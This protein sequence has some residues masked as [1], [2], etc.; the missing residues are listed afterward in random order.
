MNSK[1]HLVITGGSGMLGSVIATEFR[2]AGWTVDAPGSRELDVRDH[3]AV[4]RY[5]SDRQPEL[6][7]CAAGVIRDAPIARLSEGD[8]D[9]VWSVNF[10][11]ALTCAGVV[12][13]GMMDRGG[14]HVVFISSFSALSP[15]S[16]QTAYAASKAALIGLAR[17]LARDHGGSNIRVNTVLPGFLE[18]RMTSNVT[19][20]R[21]REVL[22][23]HS[24]S[25]LNTCDRVAAF[26]RFL[27]EEL[28]HTSGQVFQLDSR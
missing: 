8:W 19:A 5:F 22:A 20:A 14:G 2:M 25:R 16:G 6:L 23:A 12:I 24:L 11:G 7:I 10:Q 9:E 26:I 18:T 13:P 3:S 1:S 17:D 15:P 21:R 28:P 4:S 27:H